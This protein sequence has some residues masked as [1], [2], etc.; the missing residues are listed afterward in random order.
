[1]P[2]PK[3]S[4]L[5]SS[6]SVSPSFTNHVSQADVKYIMTPGALG[7]GA[8]ADTLSRI[9]QVQ[10]TIFTR[11][12]KSFKLQTQWHPPEQKP[13]V[14]FPNYLELRNSWVLWKSLAGILAK[15]TTRVISIGLSSSVKCGWHVVRFGPVLVWLGLPEA[16]GAEAS[17]AAWLLRARTIWAVLDFLTRAISSS[18]FAAWFESTVK[19]F[20]STSGTLRYQHCMKTSDKQVSAC[21]WWIDVLF[22]S[23][24][25]SGGGNNND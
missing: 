9:T 14:P 17:V 25:A 3:T 22:E 11:T 15:S 7:C 10:V 16:A 13:I 8:A 5:G 1:M 24:S 12:F 19:W 2:K 18:I 4:P 6:S 21:S 23:W 20:F